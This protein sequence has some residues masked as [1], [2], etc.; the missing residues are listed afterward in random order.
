MFRK[1]A[2]SRHT[3]SLKNKYKNKYKKRERARGDEKRARRFRKKKGGGNVV[4]NG[5]VPLAQKVVTRHSAAHDERRE[6]RDPVSGQTHESV[7]DLLLD[8]GDGRFLKLGS[9]LATVG[10][11]HGFVPTAGKNVA[12]DLGA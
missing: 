10:S 4:P 7:A 1:R 9:G 5:D 8:M 12:L 6:L 3:R 2:S 11:A